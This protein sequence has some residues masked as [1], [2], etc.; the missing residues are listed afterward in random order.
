MQRQLDALVD[1]L[2]LLEDEISELRYFLFFFFFSFIYLNRVLAPKIVNVW[3]A[4][5]LGLE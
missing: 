2:K 3:N 1:E 5:E 4:T